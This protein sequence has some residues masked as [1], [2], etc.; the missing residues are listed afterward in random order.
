M[1]FSC[2]KNASSNINSST[3]LNSSDYRKELKELYFE[4]QSMRRVMSLLDRKCNDSFEFSNLN[5]KRLLFNST[6]NEQDSLRT[7]RFLELIEDN[8]YPDKSINTERIAFYTILLHSPSSLHTRID[9]VLKK[10][11]I[12][13]KEYEA[14]RWHLDG[15]EGSPIFIS[16]LKYFTDAQV[17]NF[18][19]AK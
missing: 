4:D 12:S 9:N 5:I 10:S 1:I 14:I 18:Y 7:L 3:P 2:K 11:S 6:L 15:R 16:S 8:G 13:P 19:N 17:F